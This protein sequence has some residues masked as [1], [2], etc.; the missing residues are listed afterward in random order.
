M[1]ASVESGLKLGF[2]TLGGVGEYVY[3][4]C[5]PATFRVVNMNLHAMLATVL[6]TRRA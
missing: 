5:G 2:H 6:T 1:S 3:I 4:C